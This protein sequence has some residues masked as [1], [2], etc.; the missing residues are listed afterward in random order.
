MTFKFVFIHDARNVLSTEI[1]ACLPLIVIS[2]TDSLNTVPVISK[3]AESTFHSSLIVSKLR[4]TPTSHCSDHVP[5][6]SISSA[7]A[8]VVLALF[9]TVI[10]S[11]SINQSLLLK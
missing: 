7:S 11:F 3:E 1:S 5:V 6:S 10:P 4:N 8:S 2:S 9:K